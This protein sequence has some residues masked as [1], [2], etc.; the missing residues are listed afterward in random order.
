MD[1]VSKELSK[2]IPDEEYGIAQLVKFQYQVLNYVDYTCEEMDARYTVV[3]ELD[4][5]YSPKFIGYCL[6]DGRTAELKIHKKINY[7][8][9]RLKVSIRECPIENG[10]II[11]LTDWKREQRRKKVDNHWEDVPGIFDNWV[12][13]Y[14]K[15]EL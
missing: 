2:Q 15:V 3:T 10:D 6:K 11:Y 7:K 4:Q 13:N 12:K 14:Y 8:D 1:R 5:T 9:K